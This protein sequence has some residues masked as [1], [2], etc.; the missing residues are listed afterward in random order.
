VP[1]ALAAVVSAACQGHPAS[2]ARGG[3]PGQV[4]TEASGASHQAAQTPAARQL[5]EP[6]AVRLDALRDTEAAVAPR[7]QNHASARIELAPRLSVERS[8]EAGF[9]EHTPAAAALEP[10]AENGCAALVPGAELRPSAWST[11]GAPRGTYRFV[12]QAC[13]GSYR[14]HGEP[15][16]L[17]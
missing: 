8:G 3:T 15:F 2:Q 9:V 16:D 7:V 4:Q 11:A 10:I 1:I 17:P 6:P 14:V 13:D 12:A 5:V